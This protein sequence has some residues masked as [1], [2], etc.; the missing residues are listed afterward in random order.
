MAQYGLSVLF[1]QAL[2][3]TVVE[4]NL[5]PQDWKGALS[6]S[7]SGIEQG[8]DEPGPDEPPQEFVDRL[9]KAAGRIFGD[10]QA[11]VPFVT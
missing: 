11:G 10:P 2:L 7:L 6:G 9:L 5:T 8:P 1:T 3:D 4:A